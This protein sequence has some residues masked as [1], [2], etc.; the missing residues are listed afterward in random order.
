[1]GN[2]VIDLNIDNVA[3][4]CDVNIREKPDFAGCTGEGLFSRYLAGDNVAFEELVELYEDELSRFVYSIC[5]D[6][7][8]TK[9]LVIE[10]FGQL[11]VSGKK[12]SGESSLKTYLFT[13]GKN[14][15]FKYMKMRG[16]EKHISF[17]EVIEPLIDKNEDPY[18]YIVQDDIRRQLQDAMLEL[19]EVHRVVL[20]LLYFEDMSYLEAGQAMNKTKKQIKSLT[21]RAKLALKK[22][23]EDSGFVY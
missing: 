8:D 20:V 5:R 19:K 10:T 17:E 14:L 6:R 23:L 3:E 12:F 18:N 9:Q 1:M 13:I 16:R 22:K 11:A 7:N 2:S 21:H 4:R 15:A